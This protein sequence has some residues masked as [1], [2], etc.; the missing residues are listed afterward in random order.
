VKYLIIALILLQLPLF[1]KL[2]VHKTS[3]YKEIGIR[4]SKDYKTPPALIVSLWKYIVR[5]EL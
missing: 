3:T 4:L 5:I 1:I 2:S